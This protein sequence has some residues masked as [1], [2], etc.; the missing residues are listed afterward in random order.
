MNTQIVELR[1]TI[2]ISNNFYKQVAPI[3]GQLPTS[4]FSQNV[5]IDFIPNEV[6]VRSINYLNTTD[7]PAPGQQENS[8][9][10]T[11][12]LST[13]FNV[14][15]SENVVSYNPNQSF[16]LNKP[17][18]DNYKFNAIQ[19]DQTVV[20]GG[21]IPANMYGVLYIALE[22]IKYKDLIINDSIPY[23]QI[24]SSKSINDKIKKNK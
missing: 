6:I 18:K 23:P 1:K 22:F 7:Q 5:F 24:L 15:V 16:T 13:D 10:L 14:I 21:I 12:N 9:I 19:Y 8:F 4:N 11:S 2:I 20:N 3:P 17:I